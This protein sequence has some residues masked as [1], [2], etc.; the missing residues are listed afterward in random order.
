MTKTQLRRSIFNATDRALRAYRRWSTLYRA[1]LELGPNRYETLYLA[2]RFQGYAVA[3][4]RL[5]NAYTRTWD[6]TDGA[7]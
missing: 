6:E 5:L 7:S 4:D 2:K 3:V 1:E